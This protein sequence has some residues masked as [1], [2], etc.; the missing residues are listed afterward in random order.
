LTLEQKKELKRFYYTPYQEAVA[1]R[2]GV[3]RKE[4]PFLEEAH[5]VVQT[6]SI[7]SSSPVGSGKAIALQ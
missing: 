3:I 6:S 7:S 2:F 5:I 4:L 1:A